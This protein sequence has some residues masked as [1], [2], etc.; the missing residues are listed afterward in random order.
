[1]KIL[2]IEPFFSGSHK[3]WVES[4]K[5]YSQHNIETLTLKGVYWKWRMHGGAISLAKQF[6]SKFK[7]TLPD[8]ILTT[9]ML[10]LPVFQSLTKHLTAKIPTVTYFHEN[11]ITYPWSP[12]D[13][14]IK[15]QRDHHYGFIN[16]T[17]ALVSDSIWFNSDFHKQSFI[18]GL[19]KFLKQFPDHKE[20]DNIALIEKKINCHILRY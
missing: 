20:L 12:K 14:D 13:R 2:I 5:K 11:Q 9:D 15:K 10:N 4:Y 18:S 7:N 3:T 1:M 8:I 17:T 16:Y 6:N 19:K